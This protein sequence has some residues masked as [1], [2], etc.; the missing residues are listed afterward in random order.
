MEL[1]R[2]DFTIAHMWDPATSELLSSSCSAHMFLR[3]LFLHQLFQWV[4]F[5]CW[6]NQELTHQRIPDKFL[7]GCLLG[8]TLA[9]IQPHGELNQGD[10][11]AEN[12]HFLLWSLKCICSEWGYS[13]MNEWL[14]AEWGRVCAKSPR[15]LRIMRQHTWSLRYYREM[16]RFSNY[17]SF[18]VAHLL[19]E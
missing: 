9:L 5:L 18:R 19:I 4:R 1:E 16:Q 15:F 2:C 7:W 17:N 6:S 12:T 10:T 3:L 11:T 8:L 13:G 14:G